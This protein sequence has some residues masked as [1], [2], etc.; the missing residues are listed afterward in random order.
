MEGI[1]YVYWVVIGGLA[2]WLADRVTGSNSGLAINIA[3]GVVGA[4]LG[5][6]LTQQLGISFGE[7]TVGT[8]ATAVVGA[9]VLLIV[10]RLIKGR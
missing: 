5:G 1:D 8:L 7:D 4:F 10:V 9:I 6:W 3:V 2:G